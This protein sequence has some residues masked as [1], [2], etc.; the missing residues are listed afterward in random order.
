M[1]QVLR[2]S[3]RFKRLYVTLKDNPS[4]SKSDT[5]EHTHQDPLRSALQGVVG[6]QN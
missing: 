3:V 2:P 1:S 6:A 5:M 4:A